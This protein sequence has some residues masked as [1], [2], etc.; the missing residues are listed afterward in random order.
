M[1]R[2]KVLQPGCL[3]ANG[4]I[5]LTRRICRHAAEDPCVRG[6]RE[7]DL[8]QVIYPEPGGDGDRRNLGNF[9]RPLAHDVAA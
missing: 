9:D 4:Q 2:L 5:E 3:P 8:S 1:R 6:K 7:G